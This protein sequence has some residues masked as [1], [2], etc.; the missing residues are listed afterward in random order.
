[1]KRIRCPHCHKPLKVDPQ[2]ED[3]EDV[4]FFH[5]LSGSCNARPK[6]PPLTAEIKLVNGTPRYVVSEDKDGN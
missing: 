2:T 1:M 3:E 5:E 4:L 6:P